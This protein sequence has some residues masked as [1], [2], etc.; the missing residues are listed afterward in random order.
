MFF[1]YRWLNTYGESDNG[2]WLAGLCDVTPEK[3]VNGIDTCRLSGKEWPPTLPE[4]R[5]MCAVSL[6]PYYDNGK[7]LKAVRQML[8]AP[9]DQALGEESL[10][11][12]KQILKRRTP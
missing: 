9:R 11:N 2:V 10:A 12:I 8:T 7:Q 3:I 1:G 6:A 5:K 4:F